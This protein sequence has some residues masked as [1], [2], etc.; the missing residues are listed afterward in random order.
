M[1]VAWTRVVVEEVLEM[2]R[3]WVYFEGRAAGIADGLGAQ[4]DREESE[5]A[6]QQSGLG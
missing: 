3:S 1:Q 6:E 5:T 2:G 4:C